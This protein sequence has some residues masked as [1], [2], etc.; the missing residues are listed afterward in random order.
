MNKNIK[1]AAVALFAAVVCT[2]VAAL[3][4]APPASAATR[5]CWKV[6]CNICCQTGHGPV[7]CTQRAC[8]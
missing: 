2:G 7:I 6:D 4:S 1:R 8:V 5:T 3:L